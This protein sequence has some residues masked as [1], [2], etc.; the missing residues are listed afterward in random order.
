M[1]VRNETRAIPLI[2]IRTI[3]Y[4]IGHCMVH[5]TICYLTIILYLNFYHILL[6]IMFNRLR[7]SVAVKI[8]GLYL[9]TI[10]VY[11]NVVSSLWRFIL[12]MIIFGIATV[13]FNM[14]YNLSFFV[15]LLG[16][17]C[18]LTETLF[19]RYMGA[20]WDYRR[21]DIINIPYWL[22]PLWAIFIVLATEIS[23]RFREL[24]T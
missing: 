6:Y 21:P 15:L 5:F 22:V 1:G 11:Y 2:K 7:S 18:A 12:S 16:I 13:I 23:N 14:P 3:H 19:I 8:I 4:F 20:T 24:F 17:G 10:G 9:C